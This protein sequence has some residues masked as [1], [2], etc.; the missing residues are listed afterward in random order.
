MPLLGGEP[1]FDNQRTAGP[2]MTRHAGDRI[3]EPREGPD[4][5]DRAEQTSDDVVV[6]TKVEVQH[7][8]ARIVACGVLQPGST[9]I[10]LVDVNAIDP[11]MVLEKFRVLA[12]AARNIEYRA[13]A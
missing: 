5:T 9:Q 10:A 3:L 12:C 7:V 6:A 8:G 2:Y 13:R 11:V 4:D 1:R